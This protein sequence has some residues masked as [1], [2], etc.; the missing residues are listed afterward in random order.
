MGHCQNMEDQL[1][2]YI[3]N[4]LDALQKK[5]IKR[6]LDGCKECARFAE[7][8]GTLRKSMQ[9]IRKVDASDQL[10]VNLRE[11]IR[12]EQSRKEQSWHAVFAR[13]KWIPAV[14]FGA[15]L[16]VAGAFIADNQWS[17]PKAYSNSPTEQH[18]LSNDKNSNAL[19]ADVEAK[20]KNNAIVAQDTVLREK[21]IDNIQSRV[22]P[23]NY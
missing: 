21:N 10:I 22:T 2:G 7:Q 13:K 23:V 18:Q 20:E 3:D 8:I 15:V 19:L 11:C 6:H 12:N 4:E 1:F 9:K 16:I 14:S 5:E 17:K